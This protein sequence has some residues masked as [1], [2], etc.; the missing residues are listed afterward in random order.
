MTIIT[1]TAVALATALCLSAPRAQAFSGQPDATFGQGGGARLGFTGA[2]NTAN[3]AALQTD[4]KIVVAGT[5]RNGGWSRGPLMLA[6]YNADGST[7]TSFGDGGVG[8]YFSEAD[9]TYEARAVSVLTDGR[10][11]V[12]GNAKGPGI[13]SFESRVYVARFEAD[14][15]LDPTFGNGGIAYPLRYIRFGG[16]AMLIQADG[17]IVIAGNAGNTPHLALAR[18][19]SDATPDA[20]FNAGIGYAAV[21][22]MSRSGASAVG[23]LNGKYV[24]TGVGYDVN[25][26]SAIAVVQFNDNGTLNTAFGGD[27]IVTTWVGSKSVPY[28]L[29]FQTSITQPTKIIVA[30]EANNGTARKQFV[31]LR[32]LL[33]GSLDTTFDSDG[34]SVIGASTYDSGATSVRVV[35][36]S[37]VASRI[38]VSG[39]S[40]ADASETSRQFAV[41]KLNL[42]GGLDATFDGD[43]IARTTVD[44]AGATPS[45]MWV[46]GSR[47]TV[48]G[49]STSSYY[50][51]NV[52][53]ARYLY[54]D[55]SLDTAFDGDGLRIDDRGLTSSSARDVAMQADGSM[56]VAG[57]SRRDASDRFVAARFL[58]NGTPDAGF[59]GDGR[60][61]LDVGPGDN[62]ATS[63]L[64]EPDG[65]IILGGWGVAANSGSNA[66][67]FL[68]TRRMPD[69]SADPGFG[70]NGVVVA[71]DL[72]KSQATTLLRQPDGKLVAAG[73]LSD[74]DYYC[75]GAARFEADGQVDLDF[76]PNGT[77][78]WWIRSNTRTGGAILEPAAA[79]Q[80][81]GCIIL[82]GETG[83]N[84]GYRDVYLVRLTP[85]GIMDP[86]FGFSGHIW[87]SIG[88]GAAVARGVAVRPDGRIVVAGWAEAGAVTKAF[89]MRYLPDG[90]VD[91]TFGV[92]G[93][94]L[95]DLG[96][97]ASACAA[98]ALELQAD[99]AIVIAGDGAQGDNTDFAIARLTPAGVL[100]ASFG[101]GGQTLFDFPD[102]GEDKAAA[103]V[104]DAQGNAVLAGSSLGNF[105]VA[106]ILI[107]PVAS[108]VPETSPGIAGLFL[109]A[110]S[111]NPT[112]RGA[113]LALELKAGTRT[114]AS[115][116]DVSGRVVRRL[117]G[118]RALEAGRHTL[119]WDGR[120][121]AGRQVA[122]GVYYVRLAT[123][124][125][126]ETRKVVIVR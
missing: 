78:F 108:A 116:Y 99:G 55:G 70:T 124:G 54:S 71:R 13:F 125:G 39:F 35:Y 121:D 63:V 29:S 91:P 106:R 37:T 84:A 75:Y 118:D 114:S 38:V 41:V 51:S 111:P 15:T 68:L 16:Y 82:A 88:S 113:A 57:T 14:G 96:E 46:S 83:G 65:R 87:T 22:I 90:T 26:D 9:T 7:D 3:A 6:R 102:A 12:M 33:D 24:V 48:I 64:V 17:R 21:P 95:V 110:P 45:A 122:A 117:F 89:V 103:L 59:D 93:H 123:P 94:V 8:W 98:M 120:D 47:V 109:S 1:L 61:E 56:V 23:L 112:S 40:M 53:M 60:L 79:L 30:G 32:Y 73:C 81:D 115:V 18:L 62:E 27:G 2:N 50:N 28:A 20:S 76:G 85:D 52:A 72:Q 67:G 126:D 42:G 49:T 5:G 105:A 25:S 4:G 44:I 86:T 69:G 107:D 104:F 34:Y 100:D 80:P 97:P 10:I 43:G 31:I 92:G 11:V 119:A 74:A 36:A 58:P 77:G 101:S 19:N 66:P